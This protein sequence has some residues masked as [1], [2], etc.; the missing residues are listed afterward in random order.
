MKT[1][2]DCGFSYGLAKT[3]VWNSS[4][5]IVERTDASFRIMLIEADTFTGLFRHLE[6]TLSVPIQHI[7]FEAQRIATVESINSVLRGPLKALRWLP[8]G[9]RL[10]V[11]VF[12]RLA[13]WL[14]EGYAST[15][16]YKPGKEGRALLRNP[17]NRGLVAAI[18]VGAF[19]ALE[20]TPFSYTWDKLDGDEI[21]I[22]KPM[23]EKPELAERMAFTPP[24][25][26]PGKRIWERCPR[27]GAPTALADLEWRPERGEIIDARTGFRMVF[28]PLY[29]PHVVFREL[30]EELGK[31][32]YPVIVDAQREL[33]LRNIHEEFIATGRAGK[34][35]TRDK[36]YQEV[37]D[38]LPLRGLG[39]PV[40][41]DTQDGKLT[42]TVENP[43]N[44]HML[45][46][47]LCALY[48]LGE[49][50]EAT[51]SWQYADPSALVIEVVPK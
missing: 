31:D 51:V 26:K 3:A 22:V 13:R 50:R 16:A 6:D 11:N 10:V 40:E 39:N 14:G 8:G 32:I 12:C 27:C 5:I 28:L 18:I 7:I 20:R 25:P 34:V 41:C 47:H 45:A 37:L 2:K 46:G 9:K 1:C 48:E 30:E 42:V 33:S 15:V 35:V 17:F 23:Q 4:G 44:E 19:E 36:L 24:R 38:S 49:G 21:I 29:V 43:F